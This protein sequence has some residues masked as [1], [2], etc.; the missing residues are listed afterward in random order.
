MTYPRWR[1]CHL[2]FVHNKIFIVHWRGYL[3]RLG[4]SMLE[5]N[6][7]TNSYRY[8]IDE[9]GCTTSAATHRGALLHDA[10]RHWLKPPPYHSQ[11][12]IRPEGRPP[13]PF[14]FSGASS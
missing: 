14:V 13:A 1:A 9:V 6:D 12:P 11:S 10:E 2:V 8:D 3:S 5:N 7:L 4:T